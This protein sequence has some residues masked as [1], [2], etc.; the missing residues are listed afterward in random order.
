MRS[1]APD[2]PNRMNDVLGRQPVALRQLRVA[3]IAL[4]EKSAFVQ[5]LGS[6]G[7]MDRSVDPASAEER[8]VRGI[9]DGV[10]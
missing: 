9:D 1:A 3:R 4:A 2:R 10:D 8:R 7:A 6:G 5:Q